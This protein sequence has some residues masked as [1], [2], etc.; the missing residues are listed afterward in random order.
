MVKVLS[1]NKDSNDGR[2]LLNFKS[3]NTT[4]EGDFASV[5]YFVFKNRMSLTSSKLNI[6]DINEILDK[7]AFME[8]GNKGREYINAVT[9]V[10]VLGPARIPCAVKTRNNLH[11][12]IHSYNDLFIR[13]HSS[14][15]LCERDGNIFVLE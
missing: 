2:K 10:Y 13:S 14:L 8:A 4:L 3:V 15:P 11:S 7:I 6:A 12:T 9:I 5:A 1:I